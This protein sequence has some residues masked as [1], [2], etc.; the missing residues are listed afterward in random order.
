[1]NRIEIK[2][3]IQ[4]RIEAENAPL[5]PSER[6]MLYPES[7]YGGD[8]PWNNYGEGEGEPEPH[9]PV[10]SV[11]TDSAEDSHPWF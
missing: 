11:P 2:Q 5:T 3:A 4:D 6:Y 1:M 10:I 8:G 7:Q 9:T